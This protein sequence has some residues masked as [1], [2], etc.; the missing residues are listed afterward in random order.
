MPRVQIKFS[1]DWTDVSLKDLQSSCHLYMST[2]LNLVKDKSCLLSDKKHA[3]LGSKSKEDMITNKCADKVSLGHELELWKP[4]LA[5]IFN[6]IK[7]ETKEDHVIKENL[8]EKFKEI[9]TMDETKI[10]T[11]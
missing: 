11:N 5:T 2:Q 7:V 10:E 6:E 3:K 1:K 9:R 4:A 8:K